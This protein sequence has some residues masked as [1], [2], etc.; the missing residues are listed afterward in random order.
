[1]ILLDDGRA[2]PIATLDRVGESVLDPR[3]DLELSDSA[4]SQP[5]LDSGDEPPHQAMPPMRGVDQH[6]KKAHA[7]LP[8]FGS[9]DGESN[10]RRSI[11]GCH[12]DGIAVRRLPPHLAL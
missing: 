3:I 4:R 6:V 7:A 12:H 9:G 11:P 1:V 8:P 2:R 5:P 10:K